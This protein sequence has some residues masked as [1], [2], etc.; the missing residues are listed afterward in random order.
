MVALLAVVMKVLSGRAEKG[1]IPVALGAIQGVIQG[2]LQDLV[3][4]LLLS[5]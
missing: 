4:N 1:P 3:D 5:F 2:A